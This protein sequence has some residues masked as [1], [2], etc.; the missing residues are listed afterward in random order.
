MKKMK[1]SVHGTTG[2]LGTLIVKE[3]KKSKSFDYAGPVKREEPVP[4]CDVVID[5][6]SPEGTRSL[7]KRLSGEKLVVGTTGDLPMKELKSYSRNNTVLLVSNFAVG[8]HMFK[9]IIS[10][11]LKE[12]PDQ[13]EVSLSETHHKNKKDSPSGTAKKLAKEI[14]KKYKGKL[15][16]KSIREGKV[17]GRHVLT[18][19]SK[20]ESLEIIHD[21]KDR[22][23]FAVGA[24]NFVQ[25]AMNKKRGLFEI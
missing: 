5:V 17:V 15:S 3:L 16:I 24:L 22:N 23:V 20:K 11:L 12:I 9:E 6:S 4:I 10:V 1:V 18:L 2:K 25:M 19:N 8:I 14:D 13:W 21:V 7:L